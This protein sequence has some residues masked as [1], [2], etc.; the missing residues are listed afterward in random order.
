MNEEEQPDETSE[1]LG[2]VQGHMRDVE[3]LFDEATVK[4]IIKIQI[5]RVPQ[6][7]LDCVSVIYRLRYATN[8]SRESQSPQ[9]LSFPARFYRNILDLAYE[10]QSVSVGAKGEADPCGDFFRSSIGAIFCRR[11]SKKI[12]DYFQPWGQ[13]G[14]A[15]SGGVDMMALIGTLG[16][17]E[18][19]TTLSYDGANALNNIYRRRP[20]TAIAEIIPSLVSYA[21]N[22]YFREPPKLLFALKGG[23]LEIIESARG[24]QQGCYLGPLYCR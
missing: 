4:A 12:A 22:V 1:P 20:L 6:A 11:Y 9:R 18:G 15:V 17:E 3:H 23:G 8:K 24:V 16:F 7:H 14:V 5:C 21:A 19:C 2:R 10:R 13:Y